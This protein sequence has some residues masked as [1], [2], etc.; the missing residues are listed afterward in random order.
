MRRVIPLPNEVTDKNT[1]AT[2]TNGVLE[3]RFKKVKEQKG[4]KIE[5]E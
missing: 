5:I 4:G 3:I 2:F 1:K